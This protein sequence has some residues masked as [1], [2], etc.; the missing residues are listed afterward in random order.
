M[1]VRSHSARSGAGRLEGLRSR[2]PL[3]AYVALV[4]SI[5][6]V[7]FFRPAY[8]WD[9]LAYVALARDDGSADF[10]QVHRDLY[11]DLARVV[12]SDQYDV[13]TGNSQLTEAVKDRAYRAEVA[14]DAAA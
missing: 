7:F 3:F 6:T 8:N 1:S 12:P 5:V 9:M 2:W 14:R 10:A 11:A 13:L 4:G